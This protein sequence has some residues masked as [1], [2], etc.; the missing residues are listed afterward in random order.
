M[1]FDSNEIEEKIYLLGKPTFKTHLILFISAY[2][3]WWFQTIQ[4][5]FNTLLHDCPYVIEILADAE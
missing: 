4:E 3:N 1:N 5:H 2:F